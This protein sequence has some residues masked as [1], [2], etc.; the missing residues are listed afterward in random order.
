MESTT[1]MTKE[2]E[3]EKEM[4]DISDA[5]TK[6]FY[7]KAKD[8]SIATR[9]EEIKDVSG[10]EKILDDQLY[11]DVWKNLFDEEKKKHMVE[12]K[13]EDETRFREK[14]INGWTSYTKICVKME[15]AVCIGC[16]WIDVMTVI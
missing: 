12:A 6:T 4:K 1:D 16:G 5:D 15:N 3:Q 7:V 2:H 14:L 10:D 11:R 8:P 9:R 13:I